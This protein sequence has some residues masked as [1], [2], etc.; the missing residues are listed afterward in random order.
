ML[1][2]IK[3]NPFRIL[4]VYANASMREVVAN[5]GKMNA[6]LKVGRA[7]SFPLDLVANLG[8]VNRTGELIATAD[9]KLTI[10][11]D[12]LKAA[13]FWFFNGN[14]QFDT[15]AQNYLSNGD[16]AGAMSIWQKKESM[17]SLQNL[18]ISHLILGQYKNATSYLSKLYADYAADFLSSID[19][20]SNISESDLVQN[21]I[22]YIIEAIPDIDISL[23][24][25]PDCS[26]SWNTIAK[27]K[28]VEPIIQ[29]LTE[30]V[31]NCKKTKEESKE[32]R[33]AAGKELNRQGKALLF[34]LRQ[35]LSAK[36]IQFKNI[37]DKVANEILQASIDYYNAADDPF[38]APEAKKL[39]D[40]AEMLVSGSVIKE[41]IKE[42][43]STLEE[44]INALP[45][46][47]LK[48]EDNNIRK[49]IKKFVDL[50]DL[51][52]HSEI[53]LNEVEPILRK[54]KSK[55]SSTNSYYLS[56]SSLIVSNALNNLIAEVN[57]KQKECVNNTS[58]K[59]KLNK[60]KSA[61]DR[62]W[63]LT[64]RIEKLDMDTETRQ[65]F[66]NNKNILSNLRTQLPEDNSGNSCLIQLLIY[67]IIVL[68]I[69]TCS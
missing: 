23:L 52:C 64:E 46:V 60:Y 28:L 34:K 44:I 14:T 11:S 30:A 40:A 58:D 62:A 26:T 33:F 2:I 4:G 3:N 7:I 43:K 10:E 17:S 54:I 47:E 36:D 57:D 51:M 61:L 56:T 67:G 21:F 41:R 12:K 63:K 27:S 48:E 38:V 29:Q 42:N 50:P 18:A 66:V 13:Q 55:V 22:S 69:Y 49:A 1:D 35:V 16:L 65:R 8:A 5:R 15:I 6:F 53:L 45:P 59:D 68:L 25:H 31:T 32:V 19:I 37:S 24:I 20:R 9:S 39:L